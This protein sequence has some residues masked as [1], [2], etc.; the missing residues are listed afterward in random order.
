MDNQTEWVPMSVPFKDDLEK[1]KERRRR[2]QDGHVTRSEMAWIIQEDPMCQMLIKHT[3]GRIICAAQD[4]EFHIECIEAH[5]SGDGHVRSVEFKSDYWE[6][7]G[8]GVQRK[9]Q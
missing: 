8:E 1:F 3:L 5:P 9:V 6:G 7:W 2:T 4:V